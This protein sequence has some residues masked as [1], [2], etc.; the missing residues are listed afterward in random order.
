MLGATNLVQPR[1]DVV[2]RQDYLQRY[3]L[4][5]PPSPPAPASEDA[6]AGG[7][8][9]A[10]DPAAAAAVSSPSPGQRLAEAQLPP[11]PLPCSYHQLQQRCWQLPGWQHYR[12]AGL[13]V[14]AMGS[15][16]L[17][18]QAASASC[19]ASAGECWCCS[20][21]SILPVREVPFPRWKAQQ[22]RP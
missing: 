16:G 9:G 4:T 15:G 13:E 17:L 21:L 7:Q 12:S 5:P 11:P 2:S 22:A 20:S 10:R 6:A 8:A 18:T 1:V 19:Q 14:N 3:Y